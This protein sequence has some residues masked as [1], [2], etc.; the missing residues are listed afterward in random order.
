M[1][2]SN[3]ILVYIDG[4]Y[5]PKSQAAV[6]VFDHGLLYGDG[7]FEGIRAYDGHI[8]KLDEHLERLYASAKSIGIAIPMPFDEMKRVHA[9]I[10]V[11][12]GLRDAYFRTVVTRGVGDLG[13]DPNKCAK[14]TVFVIAD[15]IALYPPEKYEKGIAIVTA[16]VRRTPPDSLNGRMKTLNYLNNI[17]AK[18]EANHAGAQE[19]LMLNHQGLVVE[20]SAENLFLV[21]GST[22]LTP[23]VHLGALQGITRDSIIDIAR[24][25]EYK[26]HEEPFTLH[27]VYNAEEI[28]ITGTGAELMPVV[29]VDR[30]EIGTG[31]PG[32]VCRRLREAFPAYVRLHGTKI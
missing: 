19:A 27:D 32:P 16:S 2:Q 3:E 1:A 30:R 28:F 10:L 15:K 22:I 17:L 23:P 5:V 21:R 4:R 14:P 20:C 18:S 26:V 9:E 6:S 25:L 7:V 12:N 13:L 31:K 8:F 29:S 11:K 24:G